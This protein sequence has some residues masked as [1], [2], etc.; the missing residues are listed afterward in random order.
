[1]VEALLTGISEAGS[2]P[3][4]EG[5]STKDTIRVLLV[6]DEPLYAQMMM[7]RLRASKTKIKAV[8]VSCLND[9]LNHLTLNMTDVILLDL[10]L[11]ECGGLDTIDRVRSGAPSVPVVVLTGTEDERLSTLALQRG[12][13]DYLTKGI[14]EGMVV[15]SVRYAL[16]RSR[17]HEA[18]QQSEA[19]LRT[20]RMQLLQV[21]KMDSIGRLAAGIAHE[22]RNP[23]STIQMG[24]SFLKNF[25]DEFEDDA[26]EAVGEIEQAAERV[27]HIIHGVL[28]FCVPTELDLE[29]TSL[30]ACVCQI[31]PMFRHEIR[32]HDIQFA[33][34][35]D[36]GIPDLM[37]DKNHIEDHGQGIP[38]E[39]LDKLFDP[40]FT[41]KPTGSATGLGLSI[42]KNIVELHGGR[43][44]VTNRPIGG[45][46]ASLL[47]V[48]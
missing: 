46:S 13:Q 47:F 16:E 40:F 11:P 9:A 28:D 41:T 1:M 25:T 42:T 12:A 2:E 44:N 3:T 19:H 27:F 30:N 5:L 32:M 10:M 8:H 39:N 4:L 26:Q 29:P 15:R 23:L 20:T 45:V 35:L 17:A 48:P 34:Q 43:V 37:L 7:Q 21:D 36:G 24:V 18:L 33:P 14:D 6:E 38:E 22:I 31:M